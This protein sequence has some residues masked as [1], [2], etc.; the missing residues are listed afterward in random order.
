MNELR[1]V[2]KS[3]AAAP[4]L[5]AKSWLRLLGN[6]ARAVERDQAAESTGSGCGCGDCACQREKA[7]NE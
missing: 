2:M 5:V 3:L 1:R 6:G 4:V 7:I